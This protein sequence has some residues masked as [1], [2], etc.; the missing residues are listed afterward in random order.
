MGSS[1]CD[2]VA[3]MEGAT[4]RTKD[5]PLLPQ[6]H[7]ILEALQSHARG[8]NQPH[9]RDKWCCVRQQ[10]AAT[11]T[12]QPGPAHGQRRGAQVLLAQRR[13]LDQDPRQARE[14][15]TEMRSMDGERAKCAPWGL[16]TKRYC[17]VAEGSARRRTQCPAS[18]TS[19]PTTATLISPW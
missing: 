5:P 10:E 14:K 9:R 17:V 11:R 3:P 7:Q 8:G 19:G 6:M 4:A 18:R 15:R 13:K 1:G 12:Q 2:C 16:A